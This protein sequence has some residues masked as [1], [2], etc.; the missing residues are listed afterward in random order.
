MVLDWFSASEEIAFGNKL[1]E[2]FDREWRAVENKAGH[3]QKDKAQKIIAQVLQQA[4]QFGRT[5]KL[6]IYKKSQLGNSFKWKLAEFGHSK[7][8]IDTLTKDIL[9]ALR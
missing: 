1:A 8:L 9:L 2:H 6:N 4:Q 3:K 7:E 5:H